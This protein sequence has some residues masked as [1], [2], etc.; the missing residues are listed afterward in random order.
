VPAT[1]A[2][3]E[4]WLKILGA[5][6]GLVVL[7]LGAGRAWGT[8]AVKLDHVV[9]STTGVRGDV[10]EVDRKM[11]GLHDRFEGFKQEVRADMVRLTVSDTRLEGRVELVERLQGLPPPWKRTQPITA[12]GG[13]E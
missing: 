6:V 5:V 11:Q 4:T 13:D 9:A 3:F 1:P 2:D 10:A 7:V 12:V 8:L